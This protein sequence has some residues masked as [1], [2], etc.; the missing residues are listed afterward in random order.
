[1]LCT[2]RSFIQITVTY[3]DMQRAASNRT[4]CMMASAQ[5][6]LPQVRRILL[7]EILHFMKEMVEVVIN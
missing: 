4:D 6:V 3:G 5:L 1:M 2:C 7:R